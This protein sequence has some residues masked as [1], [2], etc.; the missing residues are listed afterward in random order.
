MSRNFTFYLLEQFET[1][2]TIN[3]NVY[4]GEQQIFTIIKAI[5][6]LNFFQ[7]YHLQFVKAK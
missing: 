6:I 3:G 5:F 7:F 4:E 1:V 2:Y